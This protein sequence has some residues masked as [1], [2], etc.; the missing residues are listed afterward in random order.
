M[1]NTQYAANTTEKYLASKLEDNIN[2]YAS[3]NTTFE[4]IFGYNKNNFNYNL[5]SEIIDKFN[6]FIAQKC[7]W[8]EVK[9]D[10]Y[11]RFITKEYNINIY[12]D[13]NKEN[14]IYRQY[15]TSILNIGDNKL[16]MKNLIYKTFN[17]E[18]LVD[19]SNSSSKGELYKTF[20]YIPSTNKFQER[21]RVS[22]MKYIIRDSLLILIEEAIPLKDNNDLD[23]K[24]RIFKISF[25]LEINKEY[26]DSDISKDSIYLNI[27]AA[28]QINYYI[29][30]FY[31]ILLQI[32]NNKEDINSK[33]DISDYKTILSNIKISN[34]RLLYQ[35][36]INQKIIEFSPELFPNM[37]KNNND[38]KKQNVYNMYRKKNINKIGKNIDNEFKNKIKELNEKYGIN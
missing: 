18:L 23:I 21:L 20:D 10:L 29:C 24:K 15:Y 36:E 4:Y 3:R 26:I 33:D 34:E 19:L 35:P 8:I 13:G 17:S 27:P 31:D 16:C 7:D 25:K 5:S 32:I 2:K 30:Y 9:R 38:N 6:N 12:E 28:S 37:N 11:Y 14:E 22:T 1:S